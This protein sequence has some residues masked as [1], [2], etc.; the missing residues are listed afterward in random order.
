MFAQNTLTPV[1]R[2]LTSSARVESG[3]H[4]R[5][6]NGNAPAR[7][8]G[9][10]DGRCDLHSVR[11]GRRALSATNGHE[12]PPPAGSGYF[13]SYIRSASWSERFPSKSV[14]L[15]VE[16]YNICQARMKPKSLPPCIVADLFRLGHRRHRRHRSGMCHQHHQS[17][18]FPRSFQNRFPAVSTP[19]FTISQ[20]PPFFG[21]TRRINPF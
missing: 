18:H 14:F 4:V 9:R 1:V 12:L 5:R 3:V 15:L 21:P 2:T 13:C 11:R 20:W 6:Q 8:C 16:H 10:M 17:L 19:H 7:R